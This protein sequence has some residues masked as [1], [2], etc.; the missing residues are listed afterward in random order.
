MARCVFTLCCGVAVFKDE[1]NTCPWFGESLVQV[2]TP[3]VPITVSKTVDEMRTSYPTT[4][5][6]QPRIGPRYSIVYFNCLPPGKNCQFSARIDF[7][8]NSNNN[9]NNNN[10]NHMGS[11]KSNAQGY[12][13]GLT[14]CTDLVDIA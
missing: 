7:S 1:P 11:I 14:S 4:R 12:D 8:N 2:I 10:N 6:S 3:H 9:N 5:A 13:G